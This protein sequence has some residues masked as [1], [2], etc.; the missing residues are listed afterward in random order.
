MQ[1]QTNELDNP[2]D[3]DEVAEVLSKHKNY[4]HR[5]MQD[6]SGMTLHRL[7]K[8]LDVNLYPYGAKDRNKICDELR[9]HPNIE[10]SKRAPLKYV[11]DEELQRRKEA[12]E[13]RERM[14]KLQDRIKAEALMELARLIED[15]DDLV[16]E[17]KPTDRNWRIGWKDMYHLEISI[18]ANGE[19]VFLD[20]N[21]NSK[22]D[23]NQDN[24]AKRVVNRSRRLIVYNVVDLLPAVR[25]YHSMVLELD[26]LGAKLG[27]RW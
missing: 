11:S 3:A 6:Y 4:N 25:A 8:E 10:R 17:S 19:S 23:A 1:T 24:P 5:S 27:S 14:D 12:K 21:L 13:Y 2:F 18:I 16:C 20:V 26:D 22:W 15:D 9:E 7:A